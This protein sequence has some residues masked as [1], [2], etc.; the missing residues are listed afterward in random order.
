MIYNL[1]TPSEMLLLAVTTGLGIFTVFFGLYVWSVPHRIEVRL[2]QHVSGNR[3]ATTG[4]TDFSRTSPELLEAINRRLLRQ[5][6]VASTAQMLARANVPIT[7]A[8]F[9]LSR[10][11]AAL[12]LGGL[13]AV[14][15]L[16]RV[17]LIGVAIAI[18]V[19]LVG[20][21]LPLFYV[22][23]LVNRRL[24]A[25]EAQLPDAL[26]VVAGSLQAGSGIAQAFQLIASDMPAPISEE[27]SRVNREV[28]VGLSVNEA[29][30]NLAERIGTEDIDLVA[31][32][33]TIQGRVGGN[34]VNTL[35]IISQTVRERIK[36]RGEVK[37]LTA[38][39]RLSAMV[40]S[41]VPYV[42]GAIIYLMNPKYIG[43]L[44]EPGIG[45]TMLVTAIVMALV[46]FL[47]LRKI[48][49]IAL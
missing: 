15:A 13:A 7:V 6:R 18:A 4:Q 43:R 2:S 10:V 36:L 25:F 23:F 48:T 9:I 39:Q 14:W 17:G 21:Y 40:I 47:A 28:S 20:S 3:P 45:L 38:M 34:L 1:S 32:A 12:V 8:E 49:D 11:V 33:I 42:L 19:G 44:F 31:T 30:T 37:V 16:P 22:Q 26:G 24:T 27:F 29:L 35:Q 5:R 46:G 41:A